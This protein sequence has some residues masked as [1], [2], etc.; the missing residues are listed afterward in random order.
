M[1]TDHMFSS[2]T[3]K[4]PD[5]PKEHVS[6][7]PPALCVFSRCSFVSPRALDVRDFAT[8]PVRDKPRPSRP[9]DESRALSYLHSA[10][11]VHQRL[12]PRSV[13]VNRRLVEGT[14]GSEGT[15]A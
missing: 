2:S 1:F 3:P 14:G 6:A 8:L 11:V 12:R 7:P 4:K 5:I 13:L 9:C 15:G 10:H